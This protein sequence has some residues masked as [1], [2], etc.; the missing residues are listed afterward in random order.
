MKTEIEVALD[1]IQ[2]YP[3]YCSETQ[4]S[5]VKSI[6]LPVVVPADAVFIRTLASQV[7]ERID[8]MAKKPKQGEL[9]ETRH[10][11]EKKLVGLAEE[12]GE[13]RDERIALGTKEKKLKKRLIEA[14]H[15]ADVKEFNNDR[16]K[17]ELV[18]VSDEETV[19][20]KLLNGA[21]KKDKK[22]SDDP[23]A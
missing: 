8:A 11:H 5:R 1:L 22:K 3:A 2:C 7:R 21:A 14:M 18:P 9:M 10:P 15:E 23:E 6:K 12:Y 13:F 16:V 4:L 20:V 17:I 19:K